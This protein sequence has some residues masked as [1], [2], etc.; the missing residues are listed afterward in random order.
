[1]NRGSADG[2]FAGKCRSCPLEVSIPL[3][4]ARVE[5][6]NKLVRVWICSGY[7]RTF[8]SVAVEAGESEVL[9]NRKPAHAGAR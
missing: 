7:V 3:V 4:R 9:K 5:E 2:R 8:V 1:M 6:S